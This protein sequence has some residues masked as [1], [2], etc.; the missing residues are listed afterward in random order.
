MSSRQEKAYQIYKTSRIRKTNDGWI[1]P[2]QTGQG[3]YLVKFKQLVPSC[4]CPD[5]SLRKTRCKHIQAVE[6][7]LK[8]QVED[9]IETTECQ[10]KTYSQNWS[11]YDKA[12]CNEQETF[13]EL[14]ADLCKNVPNPRY[15]FGRPRLP[16]SDLIFTCAL[17][18]YSTFSYRRF[19]SYCKQAHSKEHISKVPCYASI[20]HFMQKQEITPILHELIQQS[21]LPLKSVETEFAVDSSGFSTTRF[22]RYYSFKHGK[23]LTYR[24]WVK[25]H[26]ISGVKTN[27]I[28]GIEI[29]D[30]KATLLLPTIYT[31][32]LKP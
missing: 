30:E 11:A 6:F 7:Y 5:C 17:K 16:L 28:T 27:I 26:V 22:A 29:T 8:R 32:L 23:D 3:T 20:S 9:D 14:L 21:S 19:M 10:I 31:K 2:S 12:Q 4:T 18:V 1:V 15:N 24:N 13:M 25:A